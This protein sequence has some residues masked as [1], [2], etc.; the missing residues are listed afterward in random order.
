[1]SQPPLSS[2]TSKPSC[3]KRRFRALPPSRYFQTAAFEHYL[4]AVTSKP[5]HP[6]PTSKPSHPSFNL[7]F[8]GII[9]ET[10]FIKVCSPYLGV[11]F[12][13][14]NSIYNTVP[15]NYLII[16]LLLI[17]LYAFSHTLIIISALLSAPYQSRPYF[18]KPLPP[19][20]YLRPLL[21]NRHF[22]ALLPGRHVQT[23][24]SEP[25]F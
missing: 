22:R 1:M 12:P 8:L 20:H 9:A 10:Y 6:S 15:Y 25:Y 24:T 13:Y 23:A 7:R 2:P 3:P 16:K 4:Q 17:L 14:R 19:S 21:P 5:P 11:L 18:K